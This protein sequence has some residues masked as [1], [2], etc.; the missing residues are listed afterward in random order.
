MAILVTGG[1]GYIG[2]VTIETMLEDGAEVV[3]A[4]NLS[5]GW[6]DAVDPGIPF[7]QCDVGDREAIASIVR[8]HR[9][10]ACVH[11]AAHAAVGESVRRPDLYYGNNASQGEALLTTLVQNGV[12]SFVFS[13]TCATYGEPV[14]TPIAEDHP[15]N[16]ASPYGWS[17]LIFEKML[18]GYGHA[19][20]LKS[21]SLRYF[22]AAGATASKGER[23]DPETHLIPNILDAVLGRQPALEVYG[24]D[25]PTP[26]GSAI[27]DYIHVADLAQAHVLA[28]RHL[29]SGGESLA[30]NLGTG[31]GHSILEVI[32]TVEQVTGR[33]VPWSFGP[34]RPGDPAIL[35][36]DAS[37]AR[38]VLGW[39]A[40]LAGLPAIV[41]SA[42][43]WQRKLY[44]FSA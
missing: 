22:N 21:V 12:R 30:L 4:D 10:G 16:P 8:R 44:G 6:R 13:S 7:Y 14:R 26:D 25:Y 2:S 23:H 27:R 38:A 40:T 29:E 9:I 3:A 1:A 31:T 36:A 20:G 42:W 11:F 17:K 32:R 5:R 37:R 19:F 41:E 43:A 34:R 35:V 18:A 28:L 15:Q 24:S 39:G 33:R